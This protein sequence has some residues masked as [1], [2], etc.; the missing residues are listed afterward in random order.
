MA[1]VLYPGN[2]PKGR[3]HSPNL[4]NRAI[5][6]DHALRHIDD[7]SELN[8]NPLARIAYVQQKAKEGYRGHVLPN[9]LALR[10]LLIEC[11]ERITRDLVGG[12]PAQARVCRY[13]T[14][15]KEGLS[16][17]QIS[18]QLGLSREYVSR[19]FRPKALMLVAEVMRT[20]IRNTP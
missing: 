11:I 13:L 6:I 19:T 18:S 12:E 17:G 2:V 4:D 9:G 14:G 15:R 3:K 20:M 5:Q 16:C 8:Q 1:M 10:D 7:R